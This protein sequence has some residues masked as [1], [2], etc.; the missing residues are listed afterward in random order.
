[1]RESVY[2]FVYGTE[3]KE[4]TRIAMFFTNIYSERFA[5]PNQCLKRHRPIASPKSCR[6]IQRFSFI[7]FP[8]WSTRF[9]DASDIEFYE[10]YSVVKA[11][12]AKSTGYYSD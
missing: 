1:V 3:F 5:I 7:S 12:P 2:E 4:W 10:F 8:P 9:K 6:R 11:L